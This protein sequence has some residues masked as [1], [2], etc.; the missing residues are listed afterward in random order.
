MAESSKNEKDGKTPA[1]KA[2]ELP[3]PEVVTEQPVPAPPQY[4]QVGPTPYM[5]PMT[6]MGPG[7]QTMSHSTNVTIVQ[8][9]PQRAQPRQWDTGL[10]DCCSDMNVCLLGM[11]CYPCLECKVAT[12]MNESCCLPYCVP[13][14][15]IVLRTKIRTERNIAG[16]VMNDCSVVCTC[17][18]LALCQLAREANIARA[19]QRARPV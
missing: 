8:Q 1:S 17:P 14:W 9:Q 7:A 6:S 3:A 18:M 2:S 5:A 11:C 12:D 10:C 13:G 15:M 16:S 19:E 4:N